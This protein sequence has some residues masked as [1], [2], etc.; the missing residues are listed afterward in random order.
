MCYQ[1]PTV[2]LCYYSSK[3]CTYSVRSVRQ[4]LRK[5]I[6]ESNYV[7]PL[8]HKDQLATNPQTYYQTFPILTKLI[9]QE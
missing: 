9:G 7:Y 8:N 5:T 2:K 4:D 3:E 1:F 6:K